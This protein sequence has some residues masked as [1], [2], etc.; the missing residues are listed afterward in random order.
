[1]GSLDVR[2]TTRPIGTLLPREL[3]E[4]EQALTEAARI[5]TRE[6]G[7][8]RRTRAKL[9]TQ[10]CQRKH[11]YDKHLEN[12]IWRHILDGKE[13]PDMSEWTWQERSDWIRKTG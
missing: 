11:L 12:L 13:V 2:F 3:D 10:A 9:V 8:V 6:R 5:I 7:Q 1:M 4:Y